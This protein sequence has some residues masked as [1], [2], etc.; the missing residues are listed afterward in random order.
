MTLVPLDPPTGQRGI[1]VHIES[2]HA[3]GARLAELS[4]LVD[5]GALTLR[6]AET[7]PLAEA[8]T[9]HALLAK[10]GVRGRIVLVP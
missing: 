8:P 6:V 2:I 5:A 7:L 10:G 9:A 4:R 3:D 1:T